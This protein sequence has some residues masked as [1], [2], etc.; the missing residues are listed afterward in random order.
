MIYGRVA[1]FKTFFL[2]KAIAK[3]GSIE[4][5]VSAMMDM[6]PVGAMLRSVAFL[7]GREG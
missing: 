1:L 4:E 5:D 3:R 7:S 2:S 6:L